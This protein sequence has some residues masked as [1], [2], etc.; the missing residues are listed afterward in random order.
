MDGEQHNPQQLNHGAANSG[1]APRK[2]IHIDMDAFYASIEVRDD[3]GLRGKPVAVGGYAENRGV[4]TTCSYEAREFGCRSAMPT[5]KAMRLCP[6]LIVIKPRFDAYRRE[7]AKV[8]EILRRFTRIIEPLSLDEAY[9]DVSQLPGDPGQIARDIRGQ[10]LE[11]TGLTAS[12]GVA[13]NKLLAKIASD[14]EKPNG[15]FEI[16]PS[17]VDA[18]IRKLPVRKI[19][20]VGEKT[21]EKLT[22][23]GVRTC[24]QL[25]KFEASQLHRHFGKF[26]LQLYDLCRGIDLR[27]VQPFRERKS[28][29]TE[30]TFRQNLASLPDCLEQ[31]KP[32][33]DELYADVAAHHANRDLHKAFVKLKFEDFSITTAECLIREM[34]PKTYRQ[35]LE[36]GWHRQGKPVRLIGVGVRFRPLKNVKMIQM[37]LF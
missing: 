7:S 8:R 18:F 36:E 23:L 29:S 11:V 10:I 32:L 13:P 19:W 12:A 17:E 20:G 31:L 6:E 15:Q 1:A 37:E 27:P 21:A 14:W 24:A 35:L 4:L 34:E 3:P 30:T 5:F 25:Q 2:I 26:G 16:R 22:S 28:I 33:Y 9:L